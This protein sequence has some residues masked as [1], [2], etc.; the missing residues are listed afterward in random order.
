MMVILYDDPLG[1]FLSLERRR[2]PMTEKKQRIPWFLGSSTR[3]PWTE[4]R[5]RI[6]KPPQIA[7][8]ITTLNPIFFRPSQGSLVVV[9]RGERR[10]RRREETARAGTGQAG[11]ACR[12]NRG[13]SA[14]ARRQAEGKE[15]RRAE[16]GAGRVGFRARP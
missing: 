12:G 4:K 3:Q 7:R 16:A 10:I 15:G 9:H 11:E 5:N 6:S 13:G 14:G 8:S 2:H 1:P